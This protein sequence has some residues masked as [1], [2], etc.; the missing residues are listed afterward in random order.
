M[1]V[2]GKG[3]FRTPELLVSGLKCSSS[4]LFTRQLSDLL[5]N[6]HGKRLWVILVNSVGSGAPQM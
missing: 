1:V 2:G 4:I 3:N 5:R 6:L